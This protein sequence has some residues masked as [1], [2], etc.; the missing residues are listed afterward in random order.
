MVDSSIGPLHDPIQDCDGLHVMEVRPED[1]L[2]LV[3]YLLVLE[4]QL[5]TSHGEIV[6]VDQDSH[7]L[8][9][10][11]VHAWVGTSSSGNLPS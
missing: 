2:T 4:L 10:M 6:S 5:V 7:V 9:G 3:L 8:T 11:V 1:S